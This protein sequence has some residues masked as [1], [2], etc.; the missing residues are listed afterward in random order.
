MPDNIKIA[1]EDSLKTLAR[2]YNQLLKG[3]YVGVWL[4]LNT[5]T[6]NQNA[7]WVFYVLLLLH[8]KEL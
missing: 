4:H 7:K 3:E 8:S 1:M 5:R 2:Q 6:G